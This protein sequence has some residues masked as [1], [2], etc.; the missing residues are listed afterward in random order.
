[1]SVRELTALAI[2]IDD[3]EVHVTLRKKASVPLQSF[4]DDRAEDFERKVDQ[5]TGRSFHSVAG[6]TTLGDDKSSRIFEEIYIVPFENDERWTG[7]VSEKTGIIRIEPARTGAV[8]L[9]SRAKNSSKN[10]K[11]TS[12][13]RIIPP[14]CALHPHDRDP[15]PVGIVTRHPPC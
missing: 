5:L 7:P 10:S 3:K 15:G 4:F 2:I 14:V 8:V 12:P 9:Q 6:W 1:M 11:S 13:Q